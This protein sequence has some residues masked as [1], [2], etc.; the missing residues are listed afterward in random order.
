MN[1]IDSTFLESWI[2]PGC[3]SHFRWVFCFQQFRVRDRF[4]KCLF[5]ADIRI[6]TNFIYRH[7]LLLIFVSHMHK[8]MCICKYDSRNIFKSPDISQYIK[9]YT[10]IRINE[11]V[12]KFIKTFDILFSRSKFSNEY[13]IS[14]IVFSFHSYQYFSQF[15]IVI[16]NSW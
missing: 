12:K 8:I 2:F 15:L 14:V 4:V 3:M 9:H 6:L 5:T 1:W 13:L 11:L 7:S 10:D 16:Y